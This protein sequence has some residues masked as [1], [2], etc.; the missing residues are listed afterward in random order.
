MKKKLPT[1][2]TDEEAE[3]FVANA[4]LTEYD[5]SEMVPL[6]FEFKPKTER[7][8]MRLSKDLLN[9]VKMRAAEQGMSYQRFIRRALEYAVAGPKR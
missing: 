1:L 6:Q 7:V 4:D 9:S 8:N 3:A 2:R 5:L